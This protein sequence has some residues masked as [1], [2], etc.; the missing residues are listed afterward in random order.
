MELYLQ[1]QLLQLLQLLLHKNSTW[2]H[3]KIELPKVNFNT[4]NCKPSAVSQITVRWCTKLKMHGI[5]RLV[6]VIISPTNEKKK[7]IFKRM[8]VSNSESLPIIDLVIDM[9]FSVK[10]TQAILLNMCL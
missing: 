2:Y 9:D 6:N 1:V 3:N 5:N 10:H 4:P 7:E 8:I